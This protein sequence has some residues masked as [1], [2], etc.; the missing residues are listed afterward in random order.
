MA[1]TQREAI[2]NKAPSAELIS[3]GAQKHLKIRMAL[4]YRAMHQG[5]QAVSETTH[6]RDGAMASPTALSVHKPWS[7][8]GGV[9]FPPSPLFMPCPANAESAGLAINS[10]G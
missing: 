10:T 1:P 4:A 9:A 6:V 5:M 8:Q 2:N 7:E 3:T